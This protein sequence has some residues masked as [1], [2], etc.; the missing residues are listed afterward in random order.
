MPSFFS[1]APTDS[2]LCALAQPFEGQLFVYLDLGRVGH[3]VERADLLDERSIAGGALVSDYYT[4]KRVA[5]CADAAQP[6]A[7]HKKGNISSYVCQ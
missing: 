2:G 7:N 4:V 6:D 5:L 1:M 3:R